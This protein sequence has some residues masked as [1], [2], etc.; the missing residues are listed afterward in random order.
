MSNEAS[1]AMVRRNF[2]SRF[3]TRWLVGDGID[4]GA[5]N[6]AIGMFSQM[7]PLMTS[8]RGWDLPD[9]DAMLMEGVADESLDFVHSSHCLE[10]LQDPLVALGN[11]VRI[12]K[13]GGHVVVM[14]PDEDLYEQGIFPST[15]ND[16]HKWTFTVC[17]TGTWS[18]RSINLTALLGHFASVVS[19]QK[20]EVLD[21]GY[22]F[23]APRFDQ[24]GLVTGE[25]AIEFVLR[26]RTADEIA[27]GGRYPAA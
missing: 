19:I 14:V 25:A 10:H 23:G 11:W 6:D 8:L 4:I 24:T 5:G 7:L 1:K 9:G 13:P 18:P 16:D 3:A 12:C 15:F 2:D 20:I 17:K 27:R 22:H 26:K 21:A